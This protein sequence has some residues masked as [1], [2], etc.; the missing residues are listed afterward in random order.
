MTHFGEVPGVSGGALGRKGAAGQE[1]KEGEP[2]AGWQPARPAVA[3]GWDRG[4]GGGEPGSD[5]DGSGAG[6]LHCGKQEWRTTA[7]IGPEHPRKAQ[8][9]EH[10]V[11]NLSS[12]SGG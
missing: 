1:W 2:R 4:A 11:G 9:G 10:D 6:S 7:W 5:A 3:E 8:A 12:I